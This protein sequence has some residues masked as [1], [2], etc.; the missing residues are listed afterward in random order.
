MI[1]QKRL[2]NKTSEIRCFNIISNEKDKH[3]GLSCNRLLLKK[4]SEG[5]V[6]GEIVCPVCKAKYEI[7]NDYLILKEVS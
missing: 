3:Y 7:K 6:S 4:N 5:N 1:F 2:L